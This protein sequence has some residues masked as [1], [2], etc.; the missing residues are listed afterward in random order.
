MER[1]DCQQVADERRPP[2]EVSEYEVYG[3]F[4]DPRLQVKFFCVDVDW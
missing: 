1:G 2:G 3:A 4:L